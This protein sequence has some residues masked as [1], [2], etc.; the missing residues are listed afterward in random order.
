MNEEQAGEEGLGDARLRDAYA[1]AVA[2]RRE[3]SRGACASPD[4]LLAVVRREGREDIRLATL[5][6]VLAC[7]DCGR[8]LELL[9]SIER[10]GG[11]ATQRAVEG[12]RWRRAASVALAASVLLAITLGPGRT[13][14]DDRGEPVTRG[15]GAGLVLLAPHWSETVT[16]ASPL[17]FVWHAVPGAERYALELLTTEGA[18]AL[19]RETADTTLTVAPQHGLGAGEYRWWVSA[20][21]DDGASLRSAARPL[22]LHAP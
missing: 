14:W 9:R 16:T 15:D 21:T 11:V 19:K 2:L 5:D 13:L 3:P 22:V 1:Q 10:A 17:T 7:P 20:Q 12:L 8:E 4:A 18:V 6:H